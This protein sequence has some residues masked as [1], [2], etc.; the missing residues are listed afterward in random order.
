MSVLE[1]SEYTSEVGVTARRKQETA[2][3]S[4]AHSPGS[5]PAFPRIYAMQLT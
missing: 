5:F 3:T 1:R 2:L 4:Q